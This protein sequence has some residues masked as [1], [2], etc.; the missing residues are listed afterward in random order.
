[1]KP[2]ELEQAE[3]LE[4]L[5]LMWNGIRI[6]VAQAASVPGHGVDTEADL[7]RVRSAISPDF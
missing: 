3:K 1:M 4:Q 7:E 5:R 6:H 2:C